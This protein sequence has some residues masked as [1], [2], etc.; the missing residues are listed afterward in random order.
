MI[1]PGERLET[2]ARR[3]YDCKTMAD[4]GT[5]HGF[6]PVFMVEEGLCER[7]VA[8]D[9]SVPSLQKAAN[10][11]SGRSV[12]TVDLRAGYGLEVLK[13][14]EVD[15]VVIAG[16]GGTLISE[17]LGKNIDHTLSFGKFVLQPRTATGE[18]RRWLM[19]NGFSIVCEDI[20]NEGRF[21]PEIITARPPGVITSEEEDLSHEGVPV[22]RALYYDV[23]PW[24]LKA[25]G[26]VG[27]HVKRIIGREERILSGLLEANEVDEEKISNKREEIKYL[28]DLLELLD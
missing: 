26:P 28:E 24:I 23:P 11:C 9:I 10:L 2:I 12:D 15:G 1:R 13:K 3:L 22:D 25:S 20:V 14:G 6:L 21:M 27:A 5:D 7:A 18:L 17:I 19:E 8:A 16:M 4:I